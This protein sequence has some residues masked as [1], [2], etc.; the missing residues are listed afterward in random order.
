M[1]FDA[2]VN[3]ICYENGEPVFIE[4]EYDS[5]NMDPVAL[6]KAF[7]IYEECID[8][9]ENTFVFLVNLYNIFSFDS[10]DE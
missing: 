1:T 10:E 8:A 5:W 7:E 2:T 6:K 9:G 4:T 3:G